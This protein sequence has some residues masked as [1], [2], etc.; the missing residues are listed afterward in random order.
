MRGGDIRY[1]YMPN[2][3]S[4]E[5][6]VGWWAAQN[7]EQSLGIAELGKNGGLVDHFKLICGWMHVC[8]CFL[9]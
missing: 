5:V 6:G 3:R 8:S 4:R 7:D 2:G 1:K 9:D